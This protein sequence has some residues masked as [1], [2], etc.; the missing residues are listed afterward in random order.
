[1]PVSPGHTSPLLQI[2]LSLRWRAGPCL[3]AMAQL[4]AYCCD[5]KPGGRAGE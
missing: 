4:Q 2:E 5:P 3:V 1:M